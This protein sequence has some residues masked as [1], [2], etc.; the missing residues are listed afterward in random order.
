MADFSQDVIG[1]AQNTNT[2]AAHT[3]QDALN[4]YHI[5]AT[6]EHARQELDMQKQEQERNKFQ[7]FQGQVD[8]LNRMPEGPAKKMLVD[9]LK[10]Q[11]PQAMPGVDPGTLDLLHQDPDFAKNLGTML[12]GV[13]KGDTNIDFT[14]ANQLL[15]QAPHEVVQLAESMGQQHAMVLAGQAKA[16]GFNGRVDEMKNQNA[17]AAGSAIEKDDIIKN[18]KKNLNSLMKSADIL[19]KTN[20]ALTTKDLNLAYNDYINATAPGGAATEGKVERELPD[21]WVQKLNDIQQKIGETADIRKSPDGL[22]LVHELQANMLNVKKN[23]HQQILDQFD[24]L[25]DN[26]KSNTNPRVQATV[27]SKRASYIKAYSSGHLGGDTPPPANTIQMKDPSGNVR[28]VP[29]DQVEAAKA[30]GGTV[31]GGD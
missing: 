18:S 13:A 10:K 28:L 2:E 11:V 19:T 21:T 20:G 6:A 9:G 24:S 7:W 3:G 23:M 26:Y 22:K 5:A 16:A 12:Q 25:A 30:A 1:I 29:K 31:V 14:K 8:N 17:V 27:A 15:T 4:A